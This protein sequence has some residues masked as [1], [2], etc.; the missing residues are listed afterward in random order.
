MFTDSP[1]TPREACLRLF[2]KVQILQA[3]DSRGSNSQAGKQ[4]RVLMAP[5]DKVSGVQASALPVIHHS[6]MPCLP[7]RHVFRKQA[8]GKVGQRALDLRW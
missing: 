7:H 1:G 3:R 8:W 4:D 2:C 6:T 5:E